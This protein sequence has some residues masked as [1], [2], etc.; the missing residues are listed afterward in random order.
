[1]K[2]ILTNKGDVIL[3]D[4]LDF[5]WLNQWKWRLGHNG[6]A[7][8]YLR[9][10]VDGKRVRKQI[11][12]HRLL[13]DAPDGLHVDHIDRNRTNNQRSNLRICTPTENRAFQT[14]A[15]Q[16]KNTSSFSAPSTLLTSTS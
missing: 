13:T 12:M 2:Q 9:F 11:R 1:M 15:N 4:D 7:I 5:N 14:L 6:Y 16:S 8:R 3:V 10:T